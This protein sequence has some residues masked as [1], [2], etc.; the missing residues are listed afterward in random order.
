M[1]LPSITIICVFIFLY[2][3]IVPCAFADRGEWEFRLSNGPFAFAGRLEMRPSRNDSW[4]TVCIDTLFKA[5]TNAA[6]AAC[7][8]AG[9]VGVTQ[10]SIVD[11]GSGSNAQPIYLTAI[12]CTADQLLIQNC[13]TSALGAVGQCVHSEDVGVSCVPPP[14]QWRFR[15][16]NGTAPSNGIL[17]IRP[18]PGLPWGSAHYYFWVYNYN[19][20]DIYLK[21]RLI[22]AELGYPLN[23]TTDGRAGVYSAR[24]LYDMLKWYPTIPSY[25]YLYGCAADATDIRQCTFSPMGQNNWDYNSH[26]WLDCRPP[27][28]KKEKL[29][30]VR[31]DE[32][33]K[34]FGWRIA[35]GNFAARRNATDVWKPI[36]VGALYYEQTQVYPYTYYISPITATHGLKLLCAAAGYPNAQPVL[37]LFPQSSNYYVNG[38]LNWFSEKI[39]CTNASSIRDCV[40]EPDLENS[41]TRSAVPLGVDCYNESERTWEWEY[42]LING[43][44]NSSGLFQMRPNASAPWSIVSGTDGEMHS[45]IYGWT[46]ACR[47][48]GFTNLTASDYNAGRPYALRRDPCAFGCSSNTTLW[49]QNIGGCWKSPSLESTLSIEN[50]TS[51][52]R[53]GSFSSLTGALALD[54]QALPYNISL[55]QFRLVESTRIGNGKVEFRPRPDLDWGVIGNPYGN[56][57]G[58]D[59]QLARLLALCHSLGFLNVTNPDFLSIGTAN[60]SQESYLFGIQCDT[61]LGQTFVQNCTPTFP[62]RTPGLLDGSSFYGIDCF[63]PW[64]PQWQLE[65]GGEPWRGRLLYKYS[66]YAPFGTICN[67]YFKNNHFSWNAACHSLGYTN[68]TG[69]RYLSVGAGT[70]NIYYDDIRCTAKNFYL[71]DCDKSPLGSHNCFHGQDAGVDCFPPPD[72]LWKWEFRLIDGTAPTNGRL[73]MRPTVVSTW[74]TVCSGIFNHTYAA[75]MAACRSVGFTNVTKAAWRYGGRGPDLIYLDQID[76]SNNSP[77]NGTRLINCSGYPLGSYDCTPWDAAGVDCDPAPETPELWQFRLIGG[78]APSN[79][80]LEMRPSSNVAW[81]S[82]CRRGLYHSRT[83]LLA[84]CRSVGFEAVRPVARFFGQGKSGIYL[85]NAA[86]APGASVLSECSFS[87]LFSH[88]CTHAEDF[89]IECFPTSTATM[90][91]TGSSSNSAVAP[92]TRTSSATFN[93][94]PTATSSPTRTVIFRTAS[95]MASKSQSTSATI[96]APPSPSFIKTITATSSKSHQLPITSSQSHTFLEIV[97]NTGPSDLTKAATDTTSAANVVTVVGGLLV[98]VAAMQQGAA[99][100]L[101]RMAACEKDALDGEPLDTIVHPLW[102]RIGSGVTA[103]ARGAVL[104]NL[105]FLP[106]L[107][108][109]F[110]YHI[111]PRLTSAYTGKSLTTSRD[112]VGWPSCLVIPFAMLSEGSAMAS[113]ALISLG[114]TIDIVFGSVGLLILVACVAGWLYMIRIRIPINQ[115]RLVR[116]VRLGMLSLTDTRWEWVVDTNESKKTP[117]IDNFSFD[118][119]ALKI[120]FAVDKMRLTENSQ[121]IL[122]Q[123]NHTYGE[124]WWLYSNL[125]SFGLALVVGVA[126]GMPNNTD[127]LCRGRWAIASLAT[128]LQSVVLLTCTVP[129]QLALLGAT[130]V[131]TCVFAC[132]IAQS[133]LTGKS[134]AHEETISVIGMA[135]SLV[136]AAL[137]I[138]SIGRLIY[139]LRMGKNPF[140][141]KRRMSLSPRVS[142]LML[143]M[144][145]EMSFVGDSHSHK[146]MPEAFNCADSVVDDFDLESEDDFRTKRHPARVSVHYVHT[147]TRSL[148]EIMD[149]LATTKPADIYEGN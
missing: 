149:K 96:E 58:D 57:L 114:E 107:W 67:D 63:S 51:R 101:L 85:D 136:G 91:I 111:I 94:V 137:M 37:A 116:T 78:S 15:L 88:G 14:T 62:L 99:L 46:S 29:M 4:G 52:W 145:S 118:D 80:R 124:F 35:M 115:L 83:A 103:Y 82:V 133:T 144:D 97:K 132:L 26:L 139:E 19:Y 42:R 108:G 89:G 117:R 24:K 54:C 3:L 64:R 106:I 122:L 21:R 69:A 5:N 127:G 11:Y 36:P 12:S 81:G 30:E 28:A 92:R 74:G 105:I 41:V 7:N 18:M 98:P 13:S 48:V 16:D 20:N 131:L 27:Q 56:T 55:W 34:P 65:G 123:Y 60:R 23:E 102:F 143:P 134:L 49:L 112:F 22:C 79:G 95:L 141:R 2:T 8:S 6:V 126:E 72:E 120:S 38:W 148:Q 119:N 140:L 93:P 32:V 100:A 109:A 121:R 104:S 10:A 125:V 71:E 75:W 66:N 31:I 146:E 59:W 129:L 43:P 47:S 25:Y 9:F 142:P 33:W 135:S 73:E 45:S 84:T 68:V 50:C 70:G 90:T 77:T 138:F 53:L 86:C 87:P 113:V 1:P 61:R 130:G 76:C 40:V 110:A 128:V 147:R 39:N 44:T 17:Q